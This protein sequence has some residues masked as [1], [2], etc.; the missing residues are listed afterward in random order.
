MTTSR[1]RGHL[2][3]ASAQLDECTNVWTGRADIS[4]GDFDHQSL[5][6]LMMD[7]AKSYIEERHAEHFVTD[8]AK[9]WID[10]LLDFCF[11]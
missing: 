9:N 10:S 4:L 2:I 6:R 5:H 7:M 11:Y 1:Y 8:S 3:V